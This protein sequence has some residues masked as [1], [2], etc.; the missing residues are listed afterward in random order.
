MILSI[1][2]HYA[3]FTGQTIVENEQIFHY[4]NM[5]IT[6]LMLGDLPVY[7]DVTWTS[8][9]LKSPATRLCFWRIM[10]A[11]IKENV[12]VLHHCTRRFPPQ[13]VSNIENASISW[14][15]RDHYSV[16]NIWYIIY[17]VFLSKYC[18]HYIIYSLRGTHDT[19]TILI[20]M[21]HPNNVNII[22]Y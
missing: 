17:S 3:Y 4:L 13:T 9:R 22:I 1:T 10:R 20:P 19:Y 2:N 16:R 21:K 11:N 14:C 15:R 8:W 5:L 7:C 18:L 6:N 12:N